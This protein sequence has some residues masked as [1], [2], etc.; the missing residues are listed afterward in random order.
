[1][2]TLKYKKKKKKI[3]LHLQN[4]WIKLKRFEL[5]VMNNEIVSAELSEHFD[6]ALWTQEHSLIACAGWQQQA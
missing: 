2:K 3:F 1:M 4:D 6:W 5:N